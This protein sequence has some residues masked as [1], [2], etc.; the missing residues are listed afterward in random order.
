MLE[1]SYDSDLKLLLERNR[2]ARSGARDHQEV[3]LYKPIRPGDLYL[4]KP[5]MLALRAAGH[6]AADR[7]LADPEP[8]DR[9]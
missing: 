7:W 3:K 6:A 9:L 8:E 4:N 2:L 5:A 1:S